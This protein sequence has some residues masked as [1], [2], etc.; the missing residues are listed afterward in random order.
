MPSAPGYIVASQN[1]IEYFSDVKLQQD[2]RLLRAMELTGSTLDNHEIIMK[3][4]TTDKGT[5][6]RPHQLSEKRCRRQAR[7]CGYLYCPRAHFF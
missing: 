7:T 6:V 2:R 5:L 3:A 4:T 1:F